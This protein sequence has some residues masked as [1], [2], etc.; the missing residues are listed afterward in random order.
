MNNPF[1]LWVVMK[2]EFHSTP[3]RCLQWSTHRQVRLLVFLLLGFRNTSAFYKTYRCGVNFGGIFLL[4]IVMLVLWKYEAGWL[5]K[6]TISLIPS[7]FSY[8]SP[9][10]PSHRRYER[11]FEIICL[12]RPKTSRLPMGSLVLFLRH[13]YRVDPWMDPDTTVS[14]WNA[15][16]AQRSVKTTNK[17]PIAYTHTHTRSNDCPI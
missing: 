6:T 8:Q 11:I 7:Y 10:L 9:H 14:M 4:R 3:K 15:F 2:W 16:K 12:F 13:V 1:M 17:K 5:S